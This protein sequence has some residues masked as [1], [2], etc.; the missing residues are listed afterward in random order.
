[1]QTK[2]RRAHPRITLGDAHVASCVVVGTDGL[3][4]DAEVL[5]VS[6]DGVHV[7]VPSSGTEGWPSLR[8]RA[9]AE[10]ILDDLDQLSCEVVVVWLGGT[11][12]GGERALRAGLRIAAFEPA[13]GARWAAWIAGAGEG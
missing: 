13:Q 2:E 4:I 3:S 7:V 9:A 5:D 1:M 10:L 6:L 11:V 12:A 8:Q